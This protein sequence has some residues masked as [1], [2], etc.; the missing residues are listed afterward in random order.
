MEA[1]GVQYEMGQPGVGESNARFAQIWDGPIQVA[2]LIRSGDDWI[3][4][5]ADSDYVDPDSVDG[6]W[7]SITEIVKAI[8]SALESV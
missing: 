5:D 7:D 4:A 8:E 3:V 1:F 2:S 6:E